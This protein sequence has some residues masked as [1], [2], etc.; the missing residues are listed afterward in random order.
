MSENVI[1]KEI[2]SH[3]DKY[4]ELFRLLVQTNSYNPPGNEK[5]VATVI[6]DYLKESKLNIELFPFDDNRA[7]LF[8]TLKKSYNN[9]NLLYNA[10][11]DVVPPGNEKDW[12]YPPLSAFNKRNKVIFGRGTSDMKA[13]LTAMVI[14]LAIL[15]KLS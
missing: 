7:N 8:M 15:K 3:R 14:S 6:Q 11:M 1:R 10:H 9:K 2:E 5:N 4:I 13:A 12:K